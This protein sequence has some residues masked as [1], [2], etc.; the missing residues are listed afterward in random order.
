LLVL[1]VLEDTS[2]VAGI[3][4][5][6]RGAIIQGRVTGK[7]TTLWP[8]EVQTAKAGGINSGHI[9][10]SEFLERREIVSVIGLAGYALNS[11]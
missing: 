7:T 11:Q 3:V 1:S 6:G 9:I 5:L 4:R 8:V 10:S 2:D